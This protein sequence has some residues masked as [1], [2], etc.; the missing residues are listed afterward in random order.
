MEEALICLDTNYLIFALT[1]G[2]EEAQEVL[3]W[4]RDGEPL[5]APMAAWC[6]FLC[7]PV[8]P[9]QATTIRALVSEV[10]PFGEIH[11]QEAARLFN[12]AG[13]KRH[14]RVDAMIAGTATSLGAGLATGNRD[15]FEP[16]V[17]FGLDLV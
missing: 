15:D 1:K 5:I 9:K 11:A 3:G 8:T 13:R 16:F 7:G 17:P 10:I 2:S 4:I 12:A 14:L 6:E